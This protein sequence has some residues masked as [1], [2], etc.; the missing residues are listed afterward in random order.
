MLQKNRFDYFP[1]SV[2]EIY[3]ELEAHS[4]KDLVV[5]ETMA[6]VYPY[7]AYIYVNKK[8]KALAERLEKG[9][10]IIMKDGSFEK[11]FAEKHEE[12]LKK[13]NLAKR[14]IF[15]LDNPLNSDKNL[16]FSVLKKTY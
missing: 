9:F 6:I 1:R 11:L 3:P 13:A 15:F 7:P 14:R 8:D 10:D 4:D 5:E 2:G 16:D 12:A